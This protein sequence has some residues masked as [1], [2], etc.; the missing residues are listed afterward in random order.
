MI[1]KKVFVV[2]VEL[3]ENSRRGEG[4]MRRGSTESSRCQSLFE[5]RNAAYALV[6]FPQMWSMKTEAMKSSDITNTGTGP[7]KELMIIIVMSRLRMACNAY[8]LIP[9]LSSV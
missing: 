2:G 5:Q 6:N 8:T 4:L 7:L 9:G 3:G 1:A